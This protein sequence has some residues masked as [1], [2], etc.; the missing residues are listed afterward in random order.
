MNFR[1]Y[2]YCKTKRDN[3]DSEYEKPNTAM[4]NCIKLSL[5]EIEALY[6]FASDEG[7]HIYRL[8]QDSDSGIGCT[9]IVVNPDNDHEADITD[10]DI[11]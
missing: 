3:S 9:T 6:E 4:E 8:T 7:E 11:W 5:S 2:K 1:S 10:Y